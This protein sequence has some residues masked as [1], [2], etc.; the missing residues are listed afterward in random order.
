MSEYSAPI[1]AATAGVMLFA[2]GIIAQYQSNWGSLTVNCFIV[3]GI[4]VFGV[5]TA[6][7]SK[8]L[9]SS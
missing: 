3:S 5:A 2:T 9:L 6:R 1:I 7:I 8:N 4:I